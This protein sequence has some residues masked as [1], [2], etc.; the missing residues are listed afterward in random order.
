MEG[1]DRLCSQR[2]SCGKKDQGTQQK[3]KKSKGA[4]PA[5]FGQLTINEPDDED[6]ERG[7]K[8]LFSFD[9]LGVRTCEKEGGRPGQPEEG[10]D[11]MTHDP[12]AKAP[13]VVDTTR[14]CREAA[15]VDIL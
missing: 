5:S 3:R 1:N 13:G 2:R 10:N 14:V 6:D 11:S 12:D 15:P 4:F 8:S 7:F 9:G